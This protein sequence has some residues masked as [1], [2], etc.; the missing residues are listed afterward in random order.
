[1]LD[2]GPCG[3]LEQ[4]TYSLQI[5]NDDTLLK[6]TIDLHKD[7][8]MSNK[9][10]PLRMTPEL[11]A[12][13]G[14]NPMGACVSGSRQ[15]MIGSYLT[16]NNVI[17]GPTRKRQQSGL[18]R[19]F[20]RGAW[21]VR[22]KDDCTVVKVIPRF[23]R[24]TYGIDF[25]LNPLDIVIV[26]REEDG[27]LD[28]IS[29]PRYHCMHQQ[30]GFAYDYVDENYS[31]LASNKRFRKNTIIAK[32]PAVT[33]D[34]EWMGGREVNV[35]QMSHPA[36]IEDGIWM[37]ESAAKNM[38]VRGIET[39]TGSCGRRHYPVNR[40]GKSG[41]FK[42]FPDIGD[43]IDSTGLLFA[44]RPHDEVLDA[45]YMSRN[46]LKE[47]IYNLDRPTFAQPDARV[48]DIRVFH[49]DR[50][51]S[52]GVPES[53]SEQLRKYY[54]ADRM[55][56]LEIIKTCL[57]RDGAFGWDKM[58]ISEELNILLTYGIGICGDLLV[59]EG[60]WN[61]KQIQELQ[62]PKRYRGELLDE[63]RFEITYEYLNDIN[64]GPKF[65]DLHGKI[66]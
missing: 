41:E 14:F 2:S 35:L 44:L 31:R 43:Y 45:V 49:N 20:A 3:S 23:S 12:I 59:K 57:G 54:E 65:S 5:Y 42:I 39:R 19:E 33:D 63:W 18:E 17:D 38:R 51:S 58:R 24:R 50:A 8:A 46:R 37:S 56:Y 62:L 64:I 61:K 21:D 48:I 34:G 36:G 10:N 26:E 47:P 7:N 4:R 40:Y 9:V 60:L 30:Y 1:M 6:C 22:I 53:M 29:I 25:E 55:F 27:V 52:P 13:N 16:Q 11:A 32:S 66:Y 15:Q 28:Y